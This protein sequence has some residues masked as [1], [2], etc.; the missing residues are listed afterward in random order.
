MN[1][2]FRT[3]VLVG[4]S[5]FLS[6]GLT[7]IQMLAQLVGEDRVT[8]PAQ[9]NSPGDQTVTSPAQT[10]AQSGSRLF[11]K[12]FTLAGSSIWT[13]TGITVEPGQ[14]IVVSAEGKLRYSDAKTE[15]RPKGFPVG[16]RTS[17]AFCHLTPKDGAL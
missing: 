8:S 10:M 1:R 16:S 17:Y 7:P 11:S 4:S 3:A 14:R 12:A 9:P 13:D 15:N 6:S 2:K 5:V